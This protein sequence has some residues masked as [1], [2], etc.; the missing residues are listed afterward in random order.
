M[1]L[2]VAIVV[3]VV[4]VEVAVS[5]TIRSI[6]NC[7]SSMVVHTC[8]FFLL[9][10]VDVTLA[11]ENNAE[12]IVDLPIAAAPITRDWTTFLSWVFTSGGGRKYAAVADV[13]HWMVLTVKD[14]G[15]GISKVRVLM[16][17]IDSIYEVSSYVCYLRRQFD[18]RISILYVNH[19]KTRPSCSV[20]SSSSTRVSCRREAAPAWAYSV[21][22]S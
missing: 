17:I 3:I 13:T 21:S 18:H 5:S 19:R 12:L 22:T 20:G 2:I 10:T 9:G 6:C 7:G 8:L 16:I 11:I 15:A 1:V 4:V 14:S